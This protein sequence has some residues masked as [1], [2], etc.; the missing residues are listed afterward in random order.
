MSERIVIK[1]GSNVLSRPDGTLD[2]T[3]M[4]SLVDQ[5]V[6]LRRAGY[7]IMIVTSG[8]VAC[9][10]SI[11]RTQGTLDSVEQRQLY[12]AVGQVQLINHYSNFF[13]EY[14]I[15]IGQVLTMK[16]N[17]ADGEEYDNQKA[18][19]EVMLSNGVIPVINENDT[20][21]ITELM[22]TD[23]D[24]LSGLTASM[25]NAGILVILSNIDGIYDGDP[26][27]PASK[28]IERIEPGRDIEGYIS[29]SRSSLGRGGMRSKASIARKAA[30][31]G[32]RVIIANG[33][34]DGI[35]E[36]VILRPEEVTHTEFIPCADSQ[37]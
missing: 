6:A 31:E 18:C 17:F 15:T 24:E 21:C 12:S 7:E 13:G 28:V 32:I 20:V 30:S 10:R 5:T 16:S 23:N 35:L 34:R 2:V 36:D 1:I 25:M 19:M 22:F 4:S 26:A 3:R 27:S 29:G 14:G 9:G 8:A 11:V 33:K 37:I